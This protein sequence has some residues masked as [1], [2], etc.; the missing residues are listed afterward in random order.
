[1]QDE[2][3]PFSYYFHRRPLSEEM[4]RYDRESQ[5]AAG[6]ASSTSRR[7]KKSYA[8]Y[9]AASALKIADFGCVRSVEQ[10]VG[11][12]DDNQIA[13]AGFYRAP[14]AFIGYASKWTF[15]SEAAT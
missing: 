13:G 6:V 8:A 1:M 10:A 2:N 14:E 5:D 4:A 12:G 11:V 9:F 3:F 7:K 15:P